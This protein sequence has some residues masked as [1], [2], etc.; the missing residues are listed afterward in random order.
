MD[1]S[2]PKEGHDNSNPCKSLN[3]Y[4]GEGCNKCLKFNGILVIPSITEE[5]CIRIFPELSVL[6]Q[7][8]VCF[9]RIIISAIPYVREIRSVKQTYNF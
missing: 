3:T 7:C 1:F 8:I 5:T 9:Q 4:W 2:V 6:V